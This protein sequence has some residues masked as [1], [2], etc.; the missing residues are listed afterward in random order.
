VK[1]PDSRRSPLGIATT[2]AMCVVA[3]RAAATS[4]SDAA[5]GVARLESLLDVARQEN[6]EIQA[7]EARYRAMLQRPIQEGTLP[8]PPVG[9]HFHNEDFGRITFGESEFS[10]L[11]FSAEQEVPFPGK[12]CLPA[13]VATREAERERA[14]RAFGA[15]SATRTV[16]EV[17][18]LSNLRLLGVVLVSFGLRVAIHHVAMLEGV[19]G[20]EPITLG[21]CFGW[22][23]LGAL[24]LAVL[25]ARKVVARR[26]AGSAAEVPTLAPGHLA[27]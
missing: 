2:L 11:E 25:E 3:S 6:P 19:F 14:M 12:L 17:G 16:W 26:R 23:G 10:F 27:S 13:A 8:D 24:P 5:R 20:T 22:I 15:R 18:L 7:A 9:V 1:R 4:D 21:E